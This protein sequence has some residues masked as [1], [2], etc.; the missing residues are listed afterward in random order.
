MYYEFSKFRSLKSL[1][2]F[3]KLYD[4]EV[5]EIQNQ[6]ITGLFWTNKFDPL[7]FQI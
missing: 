5:L 6:K 4:V 3:H 1:A 2:Y 7:F